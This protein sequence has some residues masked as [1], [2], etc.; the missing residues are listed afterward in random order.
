MRSVV[1]RLVVF[2]LPI[3]AMFSLAVGVLFICG[4]LESIDLPAVV[5]D[6]TRAGSDVLFGP[7]YSDCTPNYKL[8]MAQAVRPRVLAMGTSRVMEVRQQ[9]FSQPFY[10]SGG[11]VFRAADLRPFLARI[12][13]A[14]Q[15]TTIILSLDQFMLSAE[16]ERSE[17]NVIEDRLTKCLSATELISSSWTSIYRDLAS[18]KVPLGA[19]LSP[20][21]PNA[22][23]V[24]ARFNGRGFRRDGSN[25]PGSNGFTPF[26]EV[27]DRMAKGNY[28]FQYAD[29]IAA[30]LSQEVVSFVAEAHRRGIHVAAFLPPYAPLIY[31]RMREMGRYGYVDKIMPA[32]EPRLRELDATIFDFSDV[33]AL[34]LADA[35]FIDGFHGSER[36]YAAMLAEMG[37]RDPALDGVVDV[38]AIERF[39]TLSNDPMFVVP[40]P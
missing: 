23:G 10:N 29:E 12:P 27:L 14:E 35:N 24:A 32:L 37:R 31:D 21:F 13:E 40:D 39:V 16:V 20:P 33:R 11:G 4:E 25:R 5:T 2:C 7:G 30:P 36:V 34:G 15:P 26:S 6:Q 1:V 17:T 8:R 28:R 18:R 38:A 9:F 3:V 22:I 19:L